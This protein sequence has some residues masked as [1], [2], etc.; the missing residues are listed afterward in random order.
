VAE[1]PTVKGIAYDR[2]RLFLKG[3]AHFNYLSAALDFCFDAFSS[4]EPAPT[5]LENAPGAAFDEE[6]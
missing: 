4:R 6:H 5:S 1:S 2:R 3:V